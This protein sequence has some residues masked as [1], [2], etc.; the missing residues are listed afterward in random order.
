M[1]DNE[2]LLHFIREMTN[3]MTPT[4]LIYSSAKKVNPVP[5]PLLSFV[6]SFTLRIKGAIA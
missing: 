2:I 1:G 6:L 3:T 5:L 4:A